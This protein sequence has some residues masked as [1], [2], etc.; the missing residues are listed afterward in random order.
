M[1]EYRLGLSATPR[2]QYDPAGTQALFDFFGDVCFEFSL[3]QAIGVCLVP[4]DYYIHLIELNAD[5]ME[6][7][8]ELTAKIRA[9]SWK[10]ETAEGK[11]TH[12]TN[13]L[14]SIPSADLHHELIYATDKAPQQLKD[15]NEMLREQGILFHQLTAEETSDRRVTAQILA[16]FQDGGLKVLTAKRVLDEGVN[17]PQIRRAFILASTTVERQWVQRRGR[18]LRKCDAIGK[19]HGVIHDFVTLPPVHQLEDQDAKGLV[20]SELRRVE[21]FARLARNY[22]DKDGPIKALQL[23]QSVVYGLEGA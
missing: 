14:K 2:R 10:L 4:Y 22:G 16:T 20:R 11:L 6:A 18:I 7:Y 13:L 8:V 21:E 15:V 5:E 1:F 9:L 12:L 17:I 23:M 19:T 3:D